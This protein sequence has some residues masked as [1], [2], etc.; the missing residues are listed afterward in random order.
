[1]VVIE[2]I[3]DY[4]RLSNLQRRI[5]YEAYKRGIFEKISLN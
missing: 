4:N 1:M 5:P 3:N 2:E